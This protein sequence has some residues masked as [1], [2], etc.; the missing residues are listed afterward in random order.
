M[1]TPIRANA[2]TPQPSSPS[3]AS[4]LKGV[5]QNVIDTNVTLVGQMA[6]DALVFVEHPIQSLAGMNYAM[7]FPALHP[8]TVVHSLE[9]GF[10][11][12]PWDGLMDAGGTLTGT[13]CTLG[14][15]VGIVAAV[16]APLTGGA[17]LAV[18]GAAL[19]EAEMTG[20]ACMGFDAGGIALHEVR[21]AMAKTAAE[22]QAE[23]LA[24]APYAEDEAISGLTWVVGDHL[25]DR[26]SAKFPEPTGRIVNDLIGLAGVY[27]GPV[28]LYT[29]DH[30]R[31]QKPIKATSK[32]PDTL[33][34]S[35]TA[36]AR[37]AA[38]PATKLGTGFTFSV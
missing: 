3:R 25:E 12:D 9:Q 35:S 23:G 34:L 29:P 22:A 17:S 6:K 31:P 24:T 5:A 19:T 37:L 10:H 1:A 11:D 4:S 18:A 38:P 26:I 15:F 28:P 27:D 2:I 33:T 32:G 7:L 16:A 21:G 13:L 8:L 30:K 20:Y 14:V 36:Q